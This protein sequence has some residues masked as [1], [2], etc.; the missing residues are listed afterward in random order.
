[1]KNV[2]TTIVM[3]ILLSTAHGQSLVKLFEP[4]IIS[5]GD[6]ESHITFAPDGKEAY[7][8][9]S[10]PAFTRWTICV[11]GL[12]GGKWT[13]PEVAPFSGVFNDADP[14]ITRDGKR[15]YFISDRPVDQGSTTAKDLDIWYLV[16][17]QTG[18]SEPVRMD[19]AINSP[20]NEWYPTISQSGN[21]YFGSE[22]KGGLGRC[23]LYCSR[24][25]GGKFKLIEN[26]GSSINT[27]F[28]E[29]EPLVLT[30]ESGLI[31]MAFKPG[32]QGDLYYSQKKDGKWM[33]AKALVELNS[34]GVEYSPV[35]TH[36]GKYFFFSSTR[37][38]QNGTK[39]VNYDQLVMEINAPGNG[40]GD[41]Y[42][43]TTETL[44]DILKKYKD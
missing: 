44:Q 29:F 7:F 37:S 4:G 3:M 28:S 42:F 6:Y 38:G 9:K 15:L 39:K 27:Q 11:S 31:F 24:P 8:L 5:T 32:A 16:K 30:D 41:I 22:R 35:V 14:H 2:A 19:T 12:K 25:E 43:I 20:A 26:L 13:T 21:L 36:D 10:N 23:D 18:W 34:L 33:P 40:L 17:T 1:M